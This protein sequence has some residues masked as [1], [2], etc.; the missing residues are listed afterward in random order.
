MKDHDNYTQM[1]SEV[2]V[3]VNQ[4]KQN[5]QKCQSSRDIIYASIEKSLNKILN[6]Q[7]L[8]RVHKMDFLHQQIQVDREY[9]THLFAHE[10]DIFPHVFDL[11]YDQN[12]QQLNVDIQ[13][14]IECLNLLLH[15]YEGE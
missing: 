7:T 9:F 11:D 6:D 3:S 8:E 12:R 1:L 10:I 2:N 5:M 15:D 14:A 4:V 13:N